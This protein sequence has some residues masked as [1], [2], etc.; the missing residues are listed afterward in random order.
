VTPLPDHDPLDQKLSA[1]VGGKTATALSK[2][3]GLE[4]VGDL[5]THYPRR[6]A[7]LGELTALAEL[8]LD[9]DVTIVAEVLSV[10]A[11]PMK[12]KNGTIVE[13][14]ITDGT[15]IPCK[16]TR[17]GQAGDVLRQDQRLQGQTSAHPPDL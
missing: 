5:L 2:G 16:R 8:E 13:A 10:E 11:R 3:L 12:A 9:T 15:E 4:T 17:A 6:Y 7:R 14:R 1:L